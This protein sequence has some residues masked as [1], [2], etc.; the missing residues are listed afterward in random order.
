M[1][2]NIS[3][4]MNTKSEESETETL[5]QGK[6]QH[7]QREDRPLLTDSSSQDRTRAISFIRALTTPV[8]FVFSLA[9]QFTCILL[10]CLIGN[11]STQKEMQNIN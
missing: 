8:R 7:K 3:L 2:I 4:Y 11:K 5:E 10:L 6:A 9:L 1:C